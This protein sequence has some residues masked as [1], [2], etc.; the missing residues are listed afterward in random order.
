MNPNTPHRLIEIQVEQHIVRKRIIL[1]DGQFEINI[2]FNTK[3]L[4]DLESD[5]IFTASV[6]ETGF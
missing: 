5:N 1:D 4:Y 6:Q 2:I 3:Y